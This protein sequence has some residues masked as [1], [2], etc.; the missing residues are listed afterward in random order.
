[1]I[2]KKCECE[3]TCAK[4]TLLIWKICFACEFGAHK[5]KNE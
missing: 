1:M 3:C 2:K 4:F 5:G